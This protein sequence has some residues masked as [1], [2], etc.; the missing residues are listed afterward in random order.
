MEKV[1]GFAQ[2]NH[3]DRERAMMTSVTQAV[4]LCLKAIMSHATF[5]EASCFRFNAGHEIAKLYE[6]L[7][8]SLRDEIAAESKVFAREYL[9]FRRQ[10]EADIKSIMALRS[11]PQTFQQTETDWDQMAKRIRESNYTAFVNSNDPGGVDEHLHEGWFEEALDQVRLIEEPG[12]ISQYFRY[13]PQE[14]RDELPTGLIDGVLL[15]GRFMYEHLFPVQSS[16]NIPL[17]GFPLR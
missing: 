11:Q 8:D 10:V 2:D 5:R 17:S 7:P 1:W 6:D 9:A 12:D 14:D 4:E 16:R 15:L 3:L 13:A